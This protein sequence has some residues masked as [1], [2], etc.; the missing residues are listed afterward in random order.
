MGKSGSQVGCHIVAF[1]LESQQVNAEGIGAFHPP[2]Q[3][4]TAVKCRVRN[5]YK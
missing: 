4:L 5:V 2:A 3:I 1:A